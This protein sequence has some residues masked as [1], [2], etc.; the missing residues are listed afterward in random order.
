VGEG[1]RGTGGS[2]RLGQRTGADAEGGRGVGRGAARSHVGA[3]G[4]AATD[5]REKERRGHG[6]APRVRERGGGKG[7]VGPLGPVSVRVSGFSIFS[8]LFYL[9][10]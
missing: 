6:W 10:I 8:F 7:A 4:Q 3:R 2:F 1:E 9:K 5:G